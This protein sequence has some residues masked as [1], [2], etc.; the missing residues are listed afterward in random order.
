[1]KVLMSSKKL[2]CEHT[3][4]LLIT[5]KKLGLEFDVPIREVLQPA[6]LDGIMLSKFFRAFIR[7]DDE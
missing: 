5:L 7:C 4:K 6:S 2:T 1:M 3:Y